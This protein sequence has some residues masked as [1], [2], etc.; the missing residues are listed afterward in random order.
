[1]NF[2]VGRAGVNRP[3][4]SLCP[5][6]DLPVVEQAHNGDA[7]HNIPQSRGQEPLQVVAEM[8]MPSHDRSDNLAAAGN[9]MR[10]MACAH[11]ERAR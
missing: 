8:E 4:Q 10:E 9:A 11:N 1:M 5:D 2:A 3:A 6:P 7:A